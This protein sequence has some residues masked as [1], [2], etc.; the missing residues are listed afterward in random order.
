VLVVPVPVVACVPPVVSLEL[1]SL[2]LPHAAK[3]PASAQIHH[4]A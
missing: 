1:V 3:T 4:V 2:L